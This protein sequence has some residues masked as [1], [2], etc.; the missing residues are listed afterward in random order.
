MAKKNRSGTGGMRSFKRVGRSRTPTGN[1]DAGSGFNSQGGEKLS[2][3]IET[4]DDA[5]NRGC[6]IKSPRRYNSSR[7]AR[8]RDCR[9]R[10]P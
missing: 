2:T 6:R 1:K 8:T 9:R 4:Q 7:V 10:S 3:V 5:S